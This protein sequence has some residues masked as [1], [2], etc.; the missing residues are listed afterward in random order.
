[1]EA[2]ATGEVSHCLMC[3][4]H[5]SVLFVQQGMW[6]MR[7]KSSQQSTQK[8]QLS[9]G[10]G[11]N[12][13]PLHQAFLLN[14]KP[15]EE[16]EFKTALDSRSSNSSM[17]LSYIDYIKLWEKK[18]EVKTFWKNIVC[19]LCFRIQVFVYTRFDLMNV[20][21]CLWTKIAMFT[22]ADKPWKRLYWN[23]KFTQ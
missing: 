3:W 12:W 14:S 23:E 5:N 7:S 8:A 21:S 4:S 13:T 20:F 15:C 10:K 1:M 16:K 17:R 9:E 19:F 11:N 18:S 22:W 6:K 2:S